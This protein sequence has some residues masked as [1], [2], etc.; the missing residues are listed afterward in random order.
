M[1]LKKDFANIGVW[2]L[3]LNKHWD[4]VLTFYGRQNEVKTFFILPSIAVTFQTDKPYLYSL[5]FD[6]LF[7]SIEIS[8]HPSF[9]EL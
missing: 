1:K 7:W 5:Y 6:F 3:K 9:N 4:I 2:I 8:H